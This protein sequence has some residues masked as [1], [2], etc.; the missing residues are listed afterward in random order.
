MLSA[1]SHLYQGVR[2]RTDILEKFERSQCGDDVQSA[3]KALQW[4]GRHQ[5]SIQ[6]MLDT[7]VVS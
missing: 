3:L 6:L 1:R 4:L 7:G 5:L 2:E